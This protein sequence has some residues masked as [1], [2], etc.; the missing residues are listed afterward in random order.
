M[1][2]KLKNSMKCELLFVFLGFLWT[3]LFTLTKNLFAGMEIFQEQDLYNGKLY[4]T[5]RWLIAGGALCSLLLV[6]ALILFLWKVMIPIWRSGE[7]SAVFFDKIPL[8]IIVVGILYFWYC[9]RI[10]F[11]SLKLYNAIWSYYFRY[12][13]QI[14]YLLYDSLRVMRNVAVTLAF[15]WLF[16]WMLMR[17]IAYHRCAATSWLLRRMRIYKYSSALGKKISR[18]RSILIFASVGSMISGIIAILISPY[19]DYYYYRPHYMFI[20]CTI[21]VGFQLFENIYLKVSGITSTAINALIEQIRAISNAE[22]LNEQFRLSKKSLFYEPFQQLEKIDI[23][24]RRSAEKQ[25]QAERLKID[26][27]T[28][29]SHDLKTPLTSMV[30]YTDLLKQEDLSAEARDYVDVI[31]LKQEQLKEMIQQLFELSKVTSGA[32]QFKRETLDMRK[33]VEQILGDL[34]DSIQKSGQT[35]RSDFDESPLLFIGDN[36]KMYRVVQNLLENAL[37]YS[38]ENTRIYVTVKK[39]GN[40]ICLTIKNIASY[41]MNFAADEITERFVRGDKARTTEGHGL[42]LAIASSFTQNMGGILLV[43]VD[44]DLFKVTVEFPMAEA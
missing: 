32:E 6:I 8:E 39:E 2:T 25:L 43:E 37:K 44:G 5:A 27:I 1:A 20:L 38:L 31:A 14:Y 34:D 28:N 9:W 30:G 16:L 15:L 21:F 23:A 35:V 40:Q 33:L 19:L 17:R 42:G 41:E 10:D 22:P 4:D 11:L 3:V 26:L 36:E 24:A 12:D 29:V 18:K 7:Y 13:R